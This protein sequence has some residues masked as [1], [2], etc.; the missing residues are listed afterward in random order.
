MELKDF[1]IIAVCIFFI[2]LVSGVL[3]EKNNIKTILKD[4]Q[5]LQYHQTNGKLILTNDHFREVWEEVK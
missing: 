3:I 5:V 4:K 2:G 1:T